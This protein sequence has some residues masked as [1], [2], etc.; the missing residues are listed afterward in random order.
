[1]E[2]L[3]DFKCWLEDDGK[4]EK[5]SR[6]VLQYHEAYHMKKFLLISTK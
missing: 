4:A 5:N 6:N 1:M 3:V 2:R